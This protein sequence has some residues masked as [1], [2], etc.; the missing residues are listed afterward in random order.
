[1][2]PVHARMVTMTLMDATVESKCTKRFDA[3]DML[4]PDRE[5]SVGKPDLEPAEHPLPSLNDQLKALALA[6]RIIGA[7]RDKD[8][9]ALRALSRAQSTIRLEVSTKE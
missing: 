9:S 8:Y 2:V 3:Q 7:R 5:D 6:K 1:M 4:Y